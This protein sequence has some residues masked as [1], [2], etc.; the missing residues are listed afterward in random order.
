LSATLPRAA[1]DLLERL[2]EPEPY[3]R[4]TAADALQSTFLKL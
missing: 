2:L 1:I 3:K 4:I